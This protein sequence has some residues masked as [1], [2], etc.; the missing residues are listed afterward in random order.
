MSGRIPKSGIENLQRHDTRRSDTR[1]EK[2]KLIQETEG[3][4]RTAFLGLTGFLRVWQNSVFLAEHRYQAEQCRMISMNCL[5][6]KMMCWH[7]MEQ[8]DS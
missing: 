3:Q 6:L 7:D 1:G 5:K 4:L 8:R 2:W